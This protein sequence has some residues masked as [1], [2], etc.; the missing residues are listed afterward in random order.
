MYPMGMDKEFITITLFVV[1][2]LMVLFF[3]NKEKNN[4]LKK[5]YIKHSYIFL[6]GYLIVHFQY[7]IDYVLGNTT[8]NN[9]Y[10]WYNVTYSNKSIILCVLGLVSFLL[11][12]LIKKNNFKN[13]IRTSI[14]ENKYL[15]NTFFLKIISFVCILTYYLTINPI[16]FAGMYGKIE[17]SQITIYAEFAFQISIFAC[18][19][20]N[21]LNNIHKRNNI[22]IRNFISLQGIY[23]NLIICIYLLGVILSG[24]RGPIMYL[25]LCYILNYVYLTQIK[26]KFKYILFTILG[27]AFF[28]TM[29]GQVR[30][31]DKDLSF[32][33]RFSIAISGEYT[34]PNRELEESISPSTKELAI[35]IK[36]LQAATALTPEKFDHFYGRFQFQ[37]ILGAIP[38]TTEFKNLL[39]EDNSY[40][41]Q[42]SG[43]FLTWHVLGSN[44]IYELGTSCIADLYL[45]FN[46]I[47]V[48]IGMFLFGLFLRRCELVIYSYESS[49][50]FLLVL[51]F[52]YLSYGIYIGRSM[53][54]FNLKFAVFLYLLLIIN[55]IL[56]R[57]KTKK[58]DV[59]K[60]F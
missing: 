20:Q 9:L 11:G 34:N 6:L 59:K 55:I 48:I 4:N 28:I 5:Q 22:K 39:F 31:M 49:N 27:G 24:D 29:L 43:K 18:I 26:I 40:K 2:F 50:L 33:E 36:T 47:G 58:I 3:T 56:F 14:D 13:K 19:I 45:D 32:S 30:L 42:N 23:L 7:Y 21:T 1:L 25:G 15:S 51:S 53:L 60:S 10:I 52:V 38:F 54:L 16:Y 17:M 12:Y 37:Y 46:I 57:K 35:S 41:T 44:Y 8:E